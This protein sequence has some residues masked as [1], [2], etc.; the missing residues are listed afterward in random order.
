MIRWNT[1]KQII[2][3]V[4]CV[5]LIL[6]FFFI[7]LKFTFHTIDQIRY[8]QRTAA[9][10][11]VPG[12]VLSCNLFEQRSGRHARTGYNIVCRYEY[13]GASHTTS[14]LGQGEDDSSLY[15]KAQASQNLPV[16]V[17]PEHPSEAALSRGIK[18]ILW[19]QIPL[20]SLVTLL[21]LWLILIRLRKSAGELRRNFSS[22]TRNCQWGRFSA[23]G[24]MVSSLRQGNGQVAIIENKE[25]S[26]DILLLICN[27]R[28]LFHILI[29]GNSDYPIQYI[30]PEMNH[31][32]ALNCLK[33]YEQGLPRI[34]LAKNWKENTRIPSEQGNPPALSS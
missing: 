19:V 5:I 4:L 23:H 27:G 13:E 34:K 10:K 1:A 33:S 21:P 28:G 17:N 16:F 22:R 26:K 14:N 32:E 18:N 24:E 11:E 9:W 31:K 3:A 6:V 25:D 20:L 30:S 8:G 12:A 15:E 7:F 2:H 29:D